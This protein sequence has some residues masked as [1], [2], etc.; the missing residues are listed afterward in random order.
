VFALPLRLVGDPEGAPP[1]ASQTFELEVAAKQPLFMASAGVMVQDPG[2]L[3]FQK[4]AVVQE[5]NG[6][7]GL[8]RRLVLQESTDYRWVTALPAT[9]FRVPLACCLYATIGTTADKNIF[10]SVVIGPSWYFPKLRSVLTVGGLGAKGTKEKDLQEILDTYAGGNGIVD[11][12][13]NVA[14]VPASERWYWTLTFGWTFT[15]F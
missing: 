8:Q 6:S 9:H 10:K 4:L 5:P 14:Q 11:N 7:G 15:P 2:G 13:I 1:K 3:A 12:G